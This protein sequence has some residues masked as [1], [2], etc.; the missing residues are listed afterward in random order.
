MGAFS[1]TFLALPT[2]ANIRGLKSIAVALCFGIAICLTGIV[3][4]ETVTYSWTGTIVSVEVDDGTGIYTGTQVGDTFSGT[5]TYDP[6]VANIDGLHTSDG[7]S[8]IEPGGLY[9]EY[10]PGSSSATLTDGT[11]QL[12]PSKA[13][14][15]I[16]TDEP[17]EFEDP[18]DQELFSN[19]FGHEVAEGTLLDVWGLDFD[20]GIFEFEIAYAS[21]VNMQDDLSFRP[22]PPWS[23]PG[24]P[25]DPD[26]QIAIFEIT[27][28]DGSPAFNDIFAAGGTITMAQVGDV[29]TDGK[30]PIAIFILLGEEV[31]PQPAPPP[32]P[33]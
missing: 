9:V 2:L 10:I 23:P 7:D 5:F 32:P 15:S 1:Q 26:N 31:A 27:E 13:A 22:T 21:L 29:P 6:D 4:A 28:F 20:D 11:T 25:G 3:N 17:I 12:S 16:T 8:I 14:L 33:D 30:A 18:G 24:S 19:L